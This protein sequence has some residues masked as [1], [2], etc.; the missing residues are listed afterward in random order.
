MGTV[1]PLLTILWHQQSINDVRLF[2]QRPISQKFGEETGKRR[3]YSKFFWS[4]LSRIRT[5]YGKL[6][7]ESE[8]GKIWT[9]KTMKTHTFYAV[10]SLMMLL[11]F[12]D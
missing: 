7:Y 6:R 5:K 8:C 3:T 11:S 1:N 9:R 12:F 10:T 4:M 2:L